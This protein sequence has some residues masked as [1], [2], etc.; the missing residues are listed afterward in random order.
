MQFARDT[1]EILCFA[2]CS[3]APLCSMPQLQRAD[4]DIIVCSHLHGA[5]QMLQQAYMVCMAAPFHDHKAALLLRAEGAC[6]L[7]CQQVVSLCRLLVT[8]QLCCT[9]SC[10]LRVQAML[11]KRSD[12]HS[13]STFAVQRSLLIMCK[14]SQRACLYIFRAG[15]ASGRKGTER[16]SDNAETAEFGD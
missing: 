13:W 14:V 6:S 2:C 4:I 12:F 3:T 10:I 7:Q 5:Q 15:R 16:F 11:G 1:A 9:S 8:S